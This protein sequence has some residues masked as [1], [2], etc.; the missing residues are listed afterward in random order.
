M[1][2][3]INKKFK[4]SKYLSLFALACL[5]V[6]FMFSLCCLSAC[7][8]DY[9][10]NGD[11][12]SANG[13]LDEIEN[14]II[15]IIPQS[16]ATL[17]M[18]YFVEWKVLNDKSEGPLEWVKIGVPNKYVYDIKFEGDVKNA[19]YYSDGGSF[20]RADLKRKF[21]AG[22]TAE[23]KFSFVQKRIFTKNE[24]QKTIEFGFIPGW[25]DEIE[26]KNLEV[27]WKNDDSIIYTDGEKTED[28]WLVWKKE[29]LAARHSLTTAVKYP[30]SFFKNIDLSQDY[31]KSYIRFID[32]L[33]II[34]VVAVVAG[35]IAFI[36]I[37]SYIKSDGYTSYR[38]YYGKGYRGGF[39]YYRSY[40]PFWLFGGKNKRGVDGKGKSMPILN[41]DGTK[42]SSGK[43][44][45]GHGGGSSCACACACAGGG[46]AG[47][48]RKDFYN[49]QT[50]EFIKVFKSENFGENKTNIQK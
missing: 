40:Y 17:K 5:T 37:F 9:D 31:S 48:S 39:G 36:V 43:G 30:L 3:K 29:N 28:G 26:V 25:F 8:D 49:S 19:K 20:I 15:K 22:E 2:E 16:D 7:D 46:R 21:Y 47:C 6:I 44:G 11:S 50:D 13:Y 14:Y 32:M 34:I 27:Y 41:D 4:T 35:V 1:T 38:G 24:K 18:Q 12:L 45:S 10:E 42:P 23:I 33:P